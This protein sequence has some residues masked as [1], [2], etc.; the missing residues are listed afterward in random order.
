[1]EY[2]RSAIAAALAPGLLERAIVEAYQRGYSVRRLRVVYQCSWRPILRI[3]KAHGIALR[4]PKEAAH[5]KY[6]GPDGER[7]RREASEL[8][9]FC[10]RRLR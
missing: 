4:G 10:P 2:E 8:R 7:Y 1:M 3:L 5:A 6:N 9:S